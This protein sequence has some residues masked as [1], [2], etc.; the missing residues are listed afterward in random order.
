MTEIAP[1][2]VVLVMLG[3]LLVAVMF[4]YPLGITVGAIGFV[5]GYLVF[6]HSAFD[7]I[8]ARIFAQVRSYTLLAI[9]LFIFMGLVLQRSGIA[10]TMYSA[11]YVL[12]G[13]LRGGLAIVTV[14]VGTVIAACVGVV[15]ASVS[16]LALVALPPMVKRG[17]D[18]ALAAGA[19][20]AGGTLGQLIPPSVLLVIYGPMAMISVGK[21]FMGAIVP[22]LLLSF[23]YC[24]YIAVRCLVQPHLAPAI[25]I[26][27]RNV[28]MLAK[29]TTAVKSLV[30]PALLI[31]AVM[32]SIFLGI[33]P[34]N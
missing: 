9:P 32:G 15:G 13:G 7:L 4:G 14:L 27:E 31:L 34:P 29:V 18:K 28:P 16:I 2:T 30:P 25:P 5:V 3:G 23:L 26:R 11:L 33:A 24:L 1:E 19:V 6:G 8:Y 12:F 20:C 22:G 10:D 17:Y 21:L